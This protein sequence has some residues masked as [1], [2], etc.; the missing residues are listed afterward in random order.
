MNESPLVQKYLSR[1]PKSRA[2][3]ERARAVLP[4]GVTHDARYLEPYP[5][6][7]THAQGPRKWDVDGNEYVDYAGGHGALILGH[8]HPA[9]VEAVQDQLTR[10]THYGAS[11]EIEVQWAELVTEM[12]P[13]AEKVRFTA[14]G[15]EATMLAFR[16]ARAFTGKNKILRFKTHFHG[17][18]DQVAYGAKSAD[19]GLPGGIPPGLTGD[20][21]LC[22]VNDAA[23][24]SGL[25][26]EHDDIAAIVIEPT[27]S[28]FGHVATTPEFL[29]HLRALTQQHDALLI[30]DEVISGFRAAPGGAQELYGITPDMATMAK[31]I[32]GG[33]PAGAVVGRAAVM[34]MLTF[35]DD[36]EWN[37]RRRIPHYGTY[38]ANPIAARAG[39]T[40]LE[41]I[42]ST[43]VIETAN[44]TAAVIRDGMNDVLREEGISWVTYGRFSDFHIFVNL[45]DLD[46]TPADLDGGRVEASVIKSVPGA[47]SQELRAGWLAE[48]VDSMGWPGGLV[49]AVHTPA[50]VDR[51]VS[52]FHSFLK[53]YKQGAGPQPA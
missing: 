49:S 9:I 13:C 14:S 42:R 15:T 22:P 51:T 48:G 41:L 45:D 35:T 1:T 37:R 28:T 33:F 50:E 18:H 26:Q 27:G 17:W 29:R 32:A 47:M 19:D 38:N 44:A 20:I 10:G 23:A 3:Y 36:A 5:I 21:V 12:V 34:D 7:V 43:D 39:I 40:Q 16:I 25:M 11:N 52:G 8:N 2:L 4:S 31:A 53:L 24:V 30:F 6:A 46:V